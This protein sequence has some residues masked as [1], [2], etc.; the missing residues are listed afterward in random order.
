MK[1]L[2]QIL[3][4]FFAAFFI[5]TALHAQNDLG[6]S[7]ANTKV[8]LPEIIVNGI[9]QEIEIKLTDRE[10][11]KKLEGKIIQIQINN[12]TLEKEISS[13][14]LL[15]NYDF[16]IKEALTIGIGGF[17][18]KQDVNPIPLWLSVIPPLI[19][20]LFALVLREVYTALF[21]GIWSGT[22]V[23]YFYQGSGIFSAI[24]KGFLA[25]LDTY[26]IQSLN[27]SGH[28]SIILFSM[29]IA[30][31]VSLITKNGGM[32]GVVNRLSKY[33]TGPRS[34]AFITWALG[35]LIFFDDYANTLVVG[36]AMRPL[37]DKLRISR[38]K[39]AYIIDSTAA[40]VAS[41]AFVT[42]WIGAELSYIQDGINDLNLDES[43][44]GVFFNSLAY[45]FY[46]FFTLA[47][48]VILIWKGTDFGPMLK[49]EAK[50]RAAISIADIEVEALN[51]DQ[52]AEVSVARNV[53][54]RSF[55]A[56][57]PVLVIVFGTL[58]ALLYTG[59]EQSVW[60]NKNIGFF[61]KLSETIGNSDSYL[62]LLWASLGS[63]FVA[64]VL[65]LSQR[66]LNLKDTIDSLVGGFKTMLPAVMI[67]TLAWSVALITQHLH[68]AD[69]ISQLLL[70]ASVSPYLIPTLT[71]V[72][73]ALVSFSTGSSWGTMAILYPLILPAGWLVAE[74]SGLEYD[75]SMAIF[76]NIAAAVLTG[77]VLGDHCSP[78]SDTTILS[79]LASSCPHI[80]HVRTQ[81]P[82]ALT[83]GFVAIVIGTLPAA[84]GV[85][86]WILFPAGIVGLFLVIHFLGKKPETYINP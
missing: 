37:T 9:E 69:F 73:A 72:M 65:T 44:Y 38:E 7:T 39:L 62:A 13:G 36:N 55:N 6:F 20:I 23:I 50:A 42:T 2:L 17:N 70:D 11:A 60:D 53:K 28:L 64:L 49:A 3:F 43:A 40:P 78:I 25:I 32:K 77:S 29:I 83:T 80:E 12:Q 15:V 4:L 45:S 16:P 24:F 74:N 34:G 54:P 5:H 61:E 86:P 27:N 85:S 59:W 18:F 19:A 82:Y 71:F 46:P 76:H 66:L 41:V 48:I 31:T 84:Y 63:L 26:I 21:A 51:P 47:F 8:L 10:L 81:L 33:A 30:A 67:L 79:S 1:N 58:G 75:T 68:T 22:F 56:V 52:L 57:I 35:V 14:L